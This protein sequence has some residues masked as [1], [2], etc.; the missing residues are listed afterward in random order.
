MNQRH[1]VRRRTLL[2]GAAGAAFAT[3]CGGSSKSTTT[4]TSR[5]QSTP[6]VPGAAGAAATSTATAQRGGT[7]KVA[8]PNGPTSLDPATS[9]A[10]TDVYAYRLLY[11]TLV[12]VQPDVTLAPELAQKWE[13]PDPLTWTFSL[14]NGVKF[15]D[16]TDFNAEAVRININRIK[17][18]AT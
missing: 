10:S 1:L 9:R 8:W 5:T 17:D 13:N 7:L 3:A 2:L 6:P 11:N 16:G 4:E 12:T 15:H 18:Q 14:R